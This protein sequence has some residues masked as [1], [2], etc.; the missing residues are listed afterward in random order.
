MNPDANTAARPTIPAVGG[1]VEMLTFDLLPS[2]DS[3]WG[4]ATG[5]DGNIYIAACGECTGGLS[6]FILSYDP[7]TEKLTYHIEVG[8]AIGEPADNGRATQSKIHYCLLPGSDGLLYCATHASGAPMDHPIWRPW[9]SWDDEALRFTGSYLFTFD[10]KNHRIENFGI[11]PP[12]EGSRCLAL[13]EKRRKLYGVTWPRNHFYVFDLDTRAYRDLGRF[14]HV[15]PQAVWTDR[16]GNAYTTN[17]YGRILRVDAETEEMRLLSVSCPHV[18]YR[19]G[20]HNVTYDVVPSPDGQSF[21][22]TDWGYESFLWRYDLYD[23]PEGTMHSFGR[24]FGPPDLKTDRNLELHQ[25]RGLVFG[26]DGKLYFT[27]GFGQSK[28]DR[29]TYLVRLDPRTGEREQVAELRCGDHTP[30]AI[31]SATP[32]Y[33]GNLYF[34]EAGRT[35]TRLYVY[36]PD[37][38]RKEKPVFSWKDIKQWG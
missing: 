23:G 15:N 11:G 7:D 5:R 26:A 4:L 29:R 30:A 31:A 20:W 9:N 34:A 6:V 18:S 10:P 36:R 32:D 35:P 19:N 13:D 37:S 28:L 38:A 14:G 25:A 8:P 3:T 21:W 16:D 27:M 24:A 2:H 17:D 1:R 22:G 12:R 33:Y